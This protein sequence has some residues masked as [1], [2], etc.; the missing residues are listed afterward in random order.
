MIVLQKMT[1]HLFRDVIDD[2]V[3]LALVLRDRHLVLR[4]RVRPE[5]FPSKPLKIKLASWFTVILICSLRTK[6][7]YSK[8]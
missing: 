6:A 8:I 3:E 7:L 2:D 4:L 5:Y 1:I